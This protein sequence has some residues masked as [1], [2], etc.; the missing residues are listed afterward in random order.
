MFS[1]IDMLNSMFSWNT[2]AMLLRNDSR[3]T[4]R[5]STPSM[6]RRPS[7]GT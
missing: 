3:V 2:T 5:I 4:L 1:R 6:V 7:S